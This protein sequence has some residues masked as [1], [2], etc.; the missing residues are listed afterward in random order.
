MNTIRRTAD[1]D[2]TR[3][4]RSKNYGLDLLTQWHEAAKWGELVLKFEAGVI[5]F[6]EQNTKEKPPYDLL[7]RQR[8]A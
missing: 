1:D 2:L 8:A 3:T 7:S 6:V 4:Q 5:V